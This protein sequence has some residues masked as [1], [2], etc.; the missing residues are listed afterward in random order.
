VFVAAV[1]YDAHYFDPF[2]PTQIATANNVT[3]G[4]GCHIPP[5]NQNTYKNLNDDVIMK[6]EV[7]QFIKLVNIVKQLLTNLNSSSSFFLGKNGVGIDYR[8]DDR[9]KVVKFGQRLGFNGKLKTRG[10]KKCH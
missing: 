2:I 1:Q 9:R 4:V 5:L 6:Y 8:C 10:F 3:G 7:N